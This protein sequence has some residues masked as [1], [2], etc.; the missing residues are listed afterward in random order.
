MTKVLVVNGF[1]YKNGQH[2]EILDLQDPLYHC[3]IPKF[4]IQMNGATGGLIN[5]TPML[6]GGFSYDSRT[7]LDTCHILQ[8][9]GEWIQDGIASLTTNRYLAG[10][11][12]MNGQ[13]V[14]VGGY[15]GKYLSSIELVSPNTPSMTLPI[16]L[17]Q[18][19]QPCVIRW[20]DQTIMVIGGYIGFN[21]YIAETYF[22]DLVNETIS[23]GPK[24]NKKRSH[25]ACAEMIVNGQDAI[26]VTGG[27]DA[28]ISTEIL[29]KSNLRNGWQMGKI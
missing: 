7:Y 13:L 26:V 4:P 12:V 28:K 24:L 27:Y 16:N 25:H 29:V 17:P 14:M 10:S 6:C 2:T 23:P 22:V 3:E 20:D 18:G 1:P 19:I 21:E 8:E 15:N 5:G 9:N 11:V